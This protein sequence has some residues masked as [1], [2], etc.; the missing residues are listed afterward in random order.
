VRPQGLFG[1]RARCAIDRAGARRR[2][3]LPVL[4][5]ESSI[6]GIFAARANAT[7]AQ[8]GT[9]A[10]IFAIAAIGLSLLLGNVNQISIGQAGFFGIGAYAVGFLTA[11]ESGRPGSRGRSPTLIGVALATLVG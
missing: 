11:T 6:F 9:Y 5:P 3:H 10:A 8:A 7:F 4:A 1:T 2:A